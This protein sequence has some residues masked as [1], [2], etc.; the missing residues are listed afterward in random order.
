[1]VV[2]L[3]DSSVNLNLRCWTKADDYWALLFDLTRAAKDCVEANGCTI[4]FPQI[5]VHKPAAASA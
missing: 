1:M 2:E 5:D 3:A 4:P